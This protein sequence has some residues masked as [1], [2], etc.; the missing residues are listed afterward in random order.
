MV[1]MLISEMNAIFVADDLVEFLGNHEGHL[2]NVH[3]VYRHALNLLIGKDELVT[4]T[5]QDDIP[6]MGLT[7]E[8][9]DSFAQALRAGDRMIL[10]VDRFTAANGIVSINLR[11]AKVWK[12]RSILSQDSLP[13]ANV[14]QTRLELI[15]WL[16]KQPAEGLLPLLPRLTGRSKVTQRFKDNIYSRYIADDLDAFTRAA[17]ISDWERA[18]TLADRLVGFGMGSTPSC[19]DF[20]AA[21]LVVFS[22]ADTLNPGLNPWIRK[23]NNAVAN[24]AKT[25]T[26]LIS[27]NMLRHAAD[28]KISQSHQ[29]LIKA[30][31]FKYQSDLADLASQ[32]MR[33]G[34]TSG[35]DFLLGLVCALEWFQTV[36]SNTEKEGERAWVE[37]NQPQPMPGI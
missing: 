7:I 20:L 27:A 23:F 9:G 24:K 34:A 15:S 29:Q 4:I 16:G 19:D 8:Q 25:R 22:I 6:P 32:V 37:N 10:D 17:N 28:G 1:E 3:S 14:A 18:L 35:G 30:C 11:D 26:T 36:K 33:H 5:N 31:L 2:A 13:T 21:Y 12:T